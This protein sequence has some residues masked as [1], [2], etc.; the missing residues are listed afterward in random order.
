MIKY[1]V[2]VSTVEQKLD[3]QLLAY[4]KADIV[5]SGNTDIF[6]TFQAVIFFD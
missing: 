4:D 1:Y 2:R 3:R 5:Y 6:F